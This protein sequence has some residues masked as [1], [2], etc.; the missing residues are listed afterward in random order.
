MIQTNDEIPKDLVFLRPSLVIYSLCSYLGGM[1]LLPEALLDPELDARFETLFENNR[2]WAR[3]M[4][5]TDPSFFVEQLK[6]QKPEYLWIGCSDSRVPANE[7]VGLPPGRVF[8]HRNVANLVQDIDLNVLS[9]MEYA[10]HELKIKDVIVCGHYDCGGVKAALSNKSFG[11]IDNWLRTI[12]RIADRHGKELA[13]LATEQARIDL[14]CE[15]NVRYQVLNVCKTSIVQ[16]AWAK[17]QKVV[18]HGLI[19]NLADGILKD[20]NYRISAKEQ[21]EPIFGFWD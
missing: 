5:D 15:L 18:V 8:V 20:L 9:V 2:R 12:K 13:E 7:L 21:L 16:N 14:M 17:G 10:I 11:V 1:K 4:V 3:Q 19:Y 6:A